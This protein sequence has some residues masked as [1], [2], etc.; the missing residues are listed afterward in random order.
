MKVLVTGATGF[1]GGH[2]A[3][4]LLAEGHDV[5]CLV[6]RPEAAGDLAR[7]G[8]GIVVGRV[9]DE[10]AVREAMRGREWVFH[11]AA[12][13]RTGKAP[14]SEFYETHVIGTRTLLEAARVEGVSRFVHTSTVGVHGH[15]A[16]PPA[17]EDAPFAPGDVYQ[18][19]KL[20]GELLA[21]DY[22]GRGVPV[23]VIR[24][25]PIYGPG[26]ERLL[27]VFR[28]ALRRPALLLGSGRT[29]YHMVYVD[30]LVEAFLL[31]AV[32]PE[33]IGRVFIVAGPEATTIEELY[34]R[35]ARA[36]GRDGI[37]IVRLPV[38]PVLLAADVLERWLKP[39]GIEPPIYRRRVEFFV[40]D[41][42]FTSDR[43][44]RLLGFE[45]RVS[46]D[47][48]IR[49]TLGWYREHGVLRV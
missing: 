44:R 4:R 16:S 2:L 34:R 43:A 26:D 7:Q 6:R 46:L 33:A 1:T 30:D 29:L 9:Q 19:T 32:R 10:R 37:P 20:E 28:L 5:R 40:K 39:L 18:R 48:G 11:V 23:T 49:R 15:I 8:A 24:P 36:A 17:D 13:Y 42:A 45:P 3:R 27:K 47:E 38:A 21:R 31:A 41:R 25:A 22:L 12:L 14:D 35:I